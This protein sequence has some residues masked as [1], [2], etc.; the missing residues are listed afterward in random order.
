MVGGIFVWIRLRVSFDAHMP[1]DAYGAVDR[2]EH[3]HD[4]RTVI[5]DV[6]VDGP[7]RMQTHQTIT[8]TLEVDALAVVGEEA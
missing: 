4:V 6:K 5:G 1:G 7:G 2:L 8:V 3:L